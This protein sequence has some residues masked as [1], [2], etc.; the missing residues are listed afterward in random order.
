[1]KSRPYTLTT[2]FAEYDGMFTSVQ[3]FLNTHQKIVEA[4]SFEQL[5]ALA[6]EFGQAMA[7]ADN[8]ACVVWIGSRAPRKAAGFDQW[9]HT[10]SNKLY[11]PKTAAAPVAA[12]T[13]TAQPPT[14][15]DAAALAS[16]TV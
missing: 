11:E 4:A 14:E 2:H 16:E 6:A 3:L 5:G 15:A 10:Q 8:H 7:N 13:L 12:T 1:M 9:N